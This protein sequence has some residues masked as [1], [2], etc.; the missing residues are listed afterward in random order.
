MSNIS[1][2]LVSKSDNDNHNKVSIKIRSRLPREQQKSEN[3]LVQG[4]AARRLRLQVNHKLD[5][6]C[7]DEEVTSTLTE[8]R[9][10]CCKVL[11]CSLP[12]Y[13]PL[14]LL[15]ACW[16][17]P[18]QVNER[19]PEHGPTTDESKMENIK[20]DN[21]EGIAKGPSASLRLRSK[22]EGKSLGVQTRSWSERTLA[23][24]SSMSLYGQSFSIIIIILAITLPVGMLLCLRS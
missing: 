24:R 21:G 5:H 2:G 16:P 9:I 3:S 15:L 8:V 7:N 1:D 23:F 13:V 12:M 22:Q 14:P 19:V 10:I 18:V 6:A 17:F 20:Q 11:T 4:T